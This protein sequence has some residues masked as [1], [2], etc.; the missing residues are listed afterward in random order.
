MKTNL[1]TIW[2]GT[3]GLSRMPFLTR[4][5]VPGTSDLS[6]II[7]NIPVEN[8]IGMCK[9]SDNKPGQLHGRPALF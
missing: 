8:A 9:V 2:K 6:F 7:F 3:E 5:N 1:L 4:L